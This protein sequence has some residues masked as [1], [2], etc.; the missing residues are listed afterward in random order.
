MLQMNKIIRLLLYNVVYSL[1]VI[2][3]FYYFL[4]ADS[5]DQFAALFIGALTIPWSFIFAIILSV[6]NIEIS[7]KLFDRSLLM[8]LFVLLNQIIIFLFSLSR[9]KNQ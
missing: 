1:F 3:S 4:A 7:S 5:K 8:L 2:P 9:I 6:L